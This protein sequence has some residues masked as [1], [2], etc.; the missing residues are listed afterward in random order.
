MGIAPKAPVLIVGGGPCGLML[1]MELGRRGVQSILVDSKN[2]TAINPQ[3]NA[4]QARTM[5]YFRRMGF[6]DEIRAAGLPADYPTDIAYFTRYTGLELARFELPSSAEAGAVARESGT[7]NAAELPHR[8]SQKY[9]E[10]VMRKHA[11]SL[12]ETS[13]NYGV[14]LT[15][16]EAGEQSVRA[17]VENVVTGETDTIEADYL[18]GAD[19]ARSFVRRQLGIR[20]AG[21]TGVQRD[22]F[23]GKMVAIY[24]RS[25]DFYDKVPHARA[26]M[27]WAFNP[28]RRSWCAAVN[29]QDEFAFHTQLKPDESEDVSDERA[30]ELFMQA[31][32]VSLDMELLAVDTWIAGHALVAESFGAG[33]VYIAGDAAHLFT[34]AGG[35]GYNTAVEDAVNLGWKLAATVSGVAGPGLLPSYAFERHQL[36]VRNTGYARQLAESIGNY[37]PDPGIEAEGAEGDALRKEAGIYLNGHAR[38]EF[39]IPGIT[40]G[41]RYDGSSVVCSDGSTLPPD[42]MNTYV[43]TA[44]PGGRLP[45][46]WLRDG[47]SV[48]DLL[49]FDWALLAMQGHDPGAAAGFAAAAAELGIA[50]ATIDLGG[51]DARALYEADLV[52]VR[53][54]QIVAWRGSGEGVNARSLLS[55][56]MGYESSAND[57]SL[58]PAAGTNVAA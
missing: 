37:V 40:F 36:A 38:R 20:Y 47:R 41:G 2:R 17:V 48:F 16:F 21:E 42:Q 1:A 32:G 8:V 58:P 49:G 14:R 44:A 27:Y 55:R 6:A 22:F 11:E 46:L 26:W 50:L 15:S 23:G 5:E 52:L 35:L 54:D 56:L 33:R 25:A 24:F 30:K 31:M 43:P 7:W 13:I 4:T 29:G 39:N 10:A 34:P 18:I 9:V 19:G 3:A 51:E 57:S 12:A 53:P 45:H 28:E